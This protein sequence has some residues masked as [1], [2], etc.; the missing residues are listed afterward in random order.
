MDH[1]DRLGLKEKKEYGIKGNERIWSQWGRKTFLDLE[2][3]KYYSI[4]DESVSKMNE[5]WS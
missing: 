5:K 4:L 2:Y 3:A 1:F